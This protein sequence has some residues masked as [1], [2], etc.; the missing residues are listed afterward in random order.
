MRILH[1]TLMR[2][3]H[4]RRDASSGVA[5]AH[6]SHISR[7]EAGDAAARRHPQLRRTVPG[8]H[9]RRIARSLRLHGEQ[10]PVGIPGHP[11]RHSRHVIRH[12]ERLLRLARLHRAI[13]GCPG[14]ISWR[15]HVQPPAIGCCISGVCLQFPLDSILWF[16]RGRPRI[17]SS[18]G[19]RSL[20]ARRQSRKGDNQNQGVY[21]HNTK[22]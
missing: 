17:R 8:R 5:A 16:R 14:L 19:I 21:S 15:L 6:R 10:L 12:V 13:A 22:L 7:S 11:N 4:P 3:R 1:P 18:A 20:V 2:I 9:I